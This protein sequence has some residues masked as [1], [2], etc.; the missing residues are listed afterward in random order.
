ME[1]IHLCFGHSL[2]RVQFIINWWREGLANFKSQG[3][4][5]GGLFYW[6]VPGWGNG[7]VEHLN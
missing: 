6:L 5:R 4:G 2:L 1:I 3:R 7:R